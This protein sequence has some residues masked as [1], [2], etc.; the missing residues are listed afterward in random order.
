[1]HFYFRLLNSTRE[2]WQ[3]SGI[4]S[5]I[6]NLKRILFEP[7]RKDALST[8]M[9]DYYEEVRTGKGGCFMA[10]C[11]GK[12]AEGLDFADD[13]GRAVL[14]T[15]LPYPPF[16]DARVELKRKF[17]DDQLREKT[18]SISGQKW[19]QLE[20]F[21]AT[22]QAIGRVIRH[23]R[24]HGA[25]IFL[26]T[27]FGDQV[28]KV[29]LSKWLQP[30]FQ[31]YTNIGMAVK[32]LANFFK[33]DG[34]IGLLR[35][36]S[37]AKQTAII[38]ASKGIKRPRSQQSEDSQM[39]KNEHS[40]LDIS[41]QYKNGPVVKDNVAQDIYSTSSSTITFNNVMKKSPSSVVAKP[42]TVLGQPPNIARFYTITY[43]TL[44][45]KKSMSI[46]LDFA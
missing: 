27:R 4:W 9:K 8:A 28:A 15:G 43:L 3:N 29:S 21:R 5:R 41:E 39:P 6:D 38:E 7:Q 37:V 26:D 42:S 30:F 12:V 40:T 31:K 23:S 32:S 25:V 10:V 14:V 22:N 1:M 35:Q 18:A 19:Y 24:D 36:D 16:K 44:S 20:A 33:V 13:N 46:S 45:Q 34:N 17:L 2:Y 11:R